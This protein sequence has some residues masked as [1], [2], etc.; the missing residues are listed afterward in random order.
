MHQLAEVILFFLAFKQTVEV[1]RT[2]RYVLLLI[3][4]VSILKRVMLFGGAF[5]CLVLGEDELPGRGEELIQLHVVGNRLLL[6]LFYG[7][8]PASVIRDELLDRV[9]PVEDWLALLSYPIFWIL[10]EAEADDY[11]LA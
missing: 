10:W 8:I 2:S 7:D 6:E 11:L 9:L 4:D 1:S 3:L 5:D